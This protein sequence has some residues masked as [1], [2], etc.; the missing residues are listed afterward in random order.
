MISEDNFEKKIEYFKK[1][2][3]K[4]PES[5]YAM[6]E[7]ASLYEKLDNKDEAIRYREINPPL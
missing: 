5:T 1:Q 3:Q 2:L 6:E 7:L 4:D